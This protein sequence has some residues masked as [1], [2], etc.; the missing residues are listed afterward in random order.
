MN[1]SAQH[2]RRVKE[3][4]RDFMSRFV[5]F[6]EDVLGKMAGRKS[7]GSRVVNSLSCC[8]RQNSVLA[9]SVK[10]VKMNS[11]LRRICGASRAFYCTVLK[12]IKG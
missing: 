4:R 6:M 9:I 3:K 5:Q 11:T 7:V 12:W 8:P 2:P 10:T 1:L